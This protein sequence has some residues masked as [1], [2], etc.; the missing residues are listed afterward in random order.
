MDIHLASRLL[1]ARNTYKRVRFHT[2]NN[3]LDPAEPLNPTLWGPLRQLDLELTVSEEGGA[4][5]IV[6]CETKDKW[7]ERQP[8][9]RVWLGGSQENYKCFC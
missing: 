3:K 6:P 9:C 4:D 2:C 7:R 8:V 5:R 1:R